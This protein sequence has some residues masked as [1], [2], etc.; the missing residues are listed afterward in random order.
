MLC[1][2][3]SGL[4]KGKDWF[5]WYIYESTRRFSNRTKFTLY[6]LSTYSNWY[7]MSSSKSA[8]NGTGQLR[9]RMKRR[10][11]RWPKYPFRSPLNL[12]FEK[13]VK[14][15]A[16]H[17]GEGVTARR[18]APCKLDGDGDVVKRC[19]KLI[20]SDS[21]IPRPPNPV[22]TKHRQTQLPLPSG[23]P[24]PFLMPLATGVLFDRHKREHTSGH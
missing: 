23:V 13:E 1:S 24:L 11:W 19:V 14:Y 6:L 16:I 4:L 3:L 7:M 20:V 10:H 21:K 8:L 15:T 5:D 2:A 18:D 9:S 12:N 22:N 17:R